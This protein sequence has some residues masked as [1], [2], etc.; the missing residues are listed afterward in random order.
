MINLPKKVNFKKKNNRYICSIN[1]LGNIQLS[2]LIL[3]II[4]SIETKR[5]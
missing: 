4:P 3:D 1:Y 2:Y 5:K